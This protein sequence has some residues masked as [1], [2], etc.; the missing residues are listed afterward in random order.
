MNRCR[1]VCI[2]LQAAVPVAQSTS[3]WGMKHLQGFSFSD[4]LRAEVYKLLSKL[5]GEGSEWGGGT[6]ML[7]K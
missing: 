2:K 4:K 5:A 3:Q 7:A 1:R 6:N